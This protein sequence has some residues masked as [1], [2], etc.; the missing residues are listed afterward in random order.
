MKPIA[1]SREAVDEYG[2]FVDHDLLG[3]LEHR[4]DRV[5]EIVPQCVGLSLTV[6]TQDVV[7]T[8]VADQVE[9]LAGLAVRSSLTLPVRRGGREVASLDLYAASPS[10]F[11]GHHEELAE[12]FDARAGAAVTDADLT[13]ATL[14]AAQQVPTHQR[15]GVTL[16]RAAALVGASVGIDHEAA[17]RR[18]DDSARRRGVTVDHL[19]GLV[20]E[21][22]SQR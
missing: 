15:A 5:C 3:D 17:C 1:A 13:F 10:A 6:L 12:I 11:D 22:L 4:A 8:L 20:V 18:L 16:H 14:R 7:V 21:V 9:G 19:A 2:P